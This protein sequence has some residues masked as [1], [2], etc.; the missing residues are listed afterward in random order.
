MYVV[1]STIPDVIVA[2]VVLEVA[3][4]TRDKFE[5]ILYVPTNGHATVMVVPLA[6]RVG[7]TGVASVVKGVEDVFDAFVPFAWT[8]KVYEVFPDAPVK[9]N[10]LTVL[11]VARPLGGAGMV[12]EVPVA[13][14]V[15]VLPDCTGVAID[16]A[17]M[18]VTEVD[19]AD[20]IVPP[21]TSVATTTKE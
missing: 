12:R 15:I 17:P 14:R 2:F 21:A 13:V 4:V 10:G 9:M 5:Y 20:T 18:G 6:D 1:P 19:V 7:T 16:G 3:G 8:E 11:T